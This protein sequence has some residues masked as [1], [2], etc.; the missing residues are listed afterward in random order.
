[1]SAKSFHLCP[2]L[3]DATNCSPPGS[4]V[5]GILQARMLEWVAMPFSRGSSRPRDWIH[6][7]WISCIG[8]QILYHWGTWEA[9][10]NQLFTCKWVKQNNQTVS[11][12]L[13]RASFTKGQTRFQTD[14]LRLNFHIRGHPVA[15]LASTCS[16]S[17]SC[18]L[19]GCCAAHHHVGQSLDQSAAPTA[20]AD[21]PEAPRKTKMGP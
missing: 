14:F 17:R 19:M 11:D 20:L 12:H 13:V 1:M 7:Y 16:S 9:W 15:L 21:A 2:T 3:C 5:H 4:S 6:V 18:F 10:T 8:R